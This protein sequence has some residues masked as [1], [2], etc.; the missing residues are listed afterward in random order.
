MA[1]QGQKKKKK[2]PY[3]PKERRR[4]QLG[5]DESK[6]LKKIY[7]KPAIVRMPASGKV[8]VDRVVENLTHRIQEHLSELNEGSLSDI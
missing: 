5:E 7:R 4:Q 6:R 8:D 3:K 1:L 2:C